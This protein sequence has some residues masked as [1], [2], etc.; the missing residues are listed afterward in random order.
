[1][2][3]EQMYD[4]YPGR[5]ITKMI[6]NE[7]D[8]IVVLLGQNVLNPRMKNPQ[9]TRNWVAFESGVGAG[10]GK[11]VWVIEDSQHRVNFPVPFVTDYLLI[12][13]NDEEV[14]SAGACRSLTEASANSN[15]H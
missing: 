7:C 10:S 3:F 13:N 4:K 15:C 14:I 11:M 5:Q 12:R 2:E 6:K 8:I 9:F 1:M